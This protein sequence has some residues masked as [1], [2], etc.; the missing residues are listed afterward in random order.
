MRELAEKL[1]KGIPF[2]RVDFY[3]IDGHVYFGE[4][5]FFDWGGFQPFST[6]EQDLEL[7]KLIKL[8]IHNDKMG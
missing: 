8:N 1:S 3:D 2:V 5:T 7:G 4:Y 6:Y